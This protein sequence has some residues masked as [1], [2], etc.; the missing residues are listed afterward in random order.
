MKL[1]MTPL[2]LTINAILLVFIL[3]LLVFKEPIYVTTEPAQ[4]SYAPESP[5][6]VAQLSE[7]IIAILSTGY[8][9][10]KFGELIVLEFDPDTDTFNVISNFDIRE[11]WIP[12]CV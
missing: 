8:S 7:N 11:N 2:L 6:E 12:V 9:S 3:L 1:K 4:E 10:G 5:Y